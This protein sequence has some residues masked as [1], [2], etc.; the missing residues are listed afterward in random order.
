MC[1]SLE[2]QMFLIIKKINDYISK[3]GKYNFLKK[4][5]VEFDG[6][7]VE[8]LI[9]RGVVDDNFTTLDFEI[10]KKELYKDFEI[11]I[12][13]NIYMTSFI[14]IAFNSFIYKKTYF[15]NGSKNKKNIENYLTNLD[16]AI[17]S[18]KKMD[19]ISLSK[20]GNCKKISLERVDSY[21]RIHYSD[22]SLEKD[23]YLKDV[24][25][26]YEGNNLTPKSYKVNNFVYHHYRFNNKF[27]INEVL[28]NINLKYTG[29]IET[30]ILNL[31]CSSH[32]GLKDVLEININDKQCLYLYG[33]P[34]RENRKNNFVLFINSKNKEM[35]NL[36]VDEIV[37]DNDFEVK[38]ASDKLF[39]SDVLCANSYLSE[40]LR[41]HLRDLLNIAEIR[42]IIII[43][44]LK[45]CLS[46]EDRK[47]LGFKLSGTLDENE[48]EYLKAIIY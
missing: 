32:K 33:E 39:I 4:G 47:E 44:I 34:I 23:K 15:N 10:F 22:F 24:Y 37:N 35:G 29:N 36:S 25:F 1:R 13:D 16:E 38:Y 20:I 7:S 30:Y 28:D 9:N 3:K 12:V 18:Y 45:E 31:D 40:Y 19:L 11:L 41:R 8:E 14:L 48:T 27:Y 46:L 21:E 5:F 43:E 6:Y 26:L 2:K 42:K 17:N